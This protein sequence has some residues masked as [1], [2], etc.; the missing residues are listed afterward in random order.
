MDDQSRAKEESVEEEVGIVE[1][2]LD[3]ESHRVEVEPHES[4]FSASL[5]Q[6]L[7]LPFSCVA[8]VCGECMATLEAGEVEMGFNYA[9]SPKQLARGLILVCQARPSGPGCRVRFE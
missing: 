4:I 3:G 6:G 8:G 5:R 9:L 7:A 1:I 2:L